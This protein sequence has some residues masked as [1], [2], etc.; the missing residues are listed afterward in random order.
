LENGKGSCDSDCDSKILLD[1][2]KNE[3]HS[4]HSVH[5]S[6]CS[7]NQLQ[8][9]HDKYLGKSISNKITE[10]IHRNKFLESAGKE[11]IP[12]AEEK[13][14]STKSIESSETDHGKC[15][16]N[17]KNLTDTNFNLCVP[18]SVAS[19][20]TSCNS[21]EHLSSH[22]CST[23]NTRSGNE[24][25]ETKEKAEDFL[26][27]ARKVTVH[28]NADLKEMGH[29]NG[30]NLSIDIAL[31]HLH[32][33]S[34]KEIRDVKIAK[35]KKFHQECP[36]SSGVFCVVQNPSDVPFQK[37]GATPV[38]PFCS[39]ESQGSVICTDTHLASR[40]IM[41]LNS[42]IKEKPSAECENFALAEDGA[43]NVSVRD[44]VKDSLHVCASLQLEEESFPILSQTDVCEEDALCVKEDSVTAVALADQKE[45]VSDFV[46][47]RRYSNIDNKMDAHNI[48][49]DDKDDGSTVICDRKV[50]C[51]SAVSEIKVDYNNKLVNVDFVNSVIH[52]V[53]VTKNSSVRVETG[54]NNDPVSTGSAVVDHM[55]VVSEEDFVMDT[56]FKKDC[57]ETYSDVDIKFDHNEKGN[58]NDSVTDCKEISNDCSSSSNKSQKPVFF[59]IPETSDHNVKTVLEPVIHT[60]C[61]RDVHEVGRNI[62]RSTRSSVGKVRAAMLHCMTAGRMKHTK[63]DSQEMSHDFIKVDAE[64]LSVCS[65]DDGSTMDSE[66]VALSVGETSEMKDKQNDLQEK[67]EEG[68]EM[69]MEVDQVTVETDILGKAEDLLLHTSS[70]AMT[71]Q[72]VPFKESLC[73]SNDIHIIGDL[74]KAKGNSLHTDKLISEKKNE[75]SGVLKESV[76]EHGNIDKERVIL[77]EDKRERIPEPNMDSPD[78]NDFINVDSE[79]ILSSKGLIDSEPTVKESK[80]THNVEQCSKL[81]DVTDD[82]LPTQNKFVPEIMTYMM[83]GEEDS[84]VKVDNEEDIMNN[85][86]EVLVHKLQNS[87]EPALF[88]SKESLRDIRSQDSENK[89]SDITGKVNE[90]DIHE[91]QCDSR[92][93]H[94]SNSTK[95]EFPSN[96]PRCSSETRQGHDNSECLVEEVFQKKVTVEQCDKIS[97]DRAGGVISDVNGISQDVKQLEGDES[98]HKVSSFINSVVESSTILDARG[99]DSKV[100]DL[101]DMFMGEEV[102]PEEQAIKESVLS[103]LGLQPLR[104]TQVLYNIAAF[105]K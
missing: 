58:N 70:T 104:A 88:Y 15:I 71:A 41:V 66:D 37:G 63:L 56:G 3:E 57:K 100:S 62:R 51:E 16:E 13:L 45:C 12:K 55:K 52:D 6:P 8:T 38:I 94:A 34:A 17:E 47:D 91:S 7:E 14:V 30:Q 98:L 9:Y 35:K 60:D 42:S 86:D 82:K 31:Y 28:E 83:K 21:A 4:A 105:T 81:K 2:T 68:K 5:G 85:V 54:N 43:S 67:K 59:E 48:N 65:T 22:D 10:L 72:G 33:K 18:E 78:A 44:V 96:T 46:V 50:D 80:S 73:H 84:E 77:P 36:S 20:K 87:I 102:S 53:E 101:K 19:E 1:E 40:D 23:H 39:G 11:L 93:E 69:E 76:V 26:P 89:S 27:A 90:S 79:R 95:E 64:S 61:E 103:A 97:K 49:L 25:S 32:E 29:K 24:V 92:H 74:S 75:M 99:C